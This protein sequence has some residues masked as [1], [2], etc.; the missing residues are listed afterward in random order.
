MKIIISPAKKLNYDSEKY[1]RETTQIQ[2]ATEAEKLIKKLKKMKPQ[3]ISDLM[4]LS[5]NLA[6]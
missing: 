6:D 2:F 5:Q 4:H 1:L 3:A